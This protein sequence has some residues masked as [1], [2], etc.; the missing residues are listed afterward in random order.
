MNKQLFDNADFLKHLFDSVPSF[1]FIVN[2][3]VQI[4]HLNAAA[5]K[6]VGVTENLAL[7][8]RGGEVLHCI[9]STETSGGCGRAPH[10]TDCVIRN[11]VGKAFRGEKVHRDTT[12]LELRNGEAATVVHIMVTASPLH[13]EGKNFVLLILED[14][15][16]LKKIEE[17]L[18][19]QASLLE[20]ANRE[21]E[22]FSYSVSH[23]LK[24]PL[25]SICGFSDILMKDY[26]A[27]LDEAGRDYLTRISSAGARMTQLID[28]MLGLARVTQ[29]GLVRQDVDLSALARDIA[30]D[31]KKNSAGRSIE[32]SIAPAPRANCDGRLVRIALENLIGNAVK[33]TSA[34]SRARIEF[35]ALMRDNVPV[36]FVRDDGSGFDMQYAANLFTPF[37]RL[38]NTAQFPGSGIG[39]AT[40]RRIIHRHG[41]HIWAESAVE[42][43]ATFYFTL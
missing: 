22:A 6:L 27:R 9:H 25:R 26:E 43:G 2:E 36:Y 40:V 7:F 20:A 37:K 1:I 31:V 33:F 29:D 15:T 38:H 42:K 41:G 21:L 12:T 13:Y 11:S 34:H 17:E 32:F 5:L 8:Q 35:G 14:I 30:N 24:S 19:L 28:D 39:L 16:S 23:D 4:R 10:C 18:R 3:D